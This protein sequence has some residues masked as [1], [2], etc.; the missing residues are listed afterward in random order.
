MPEQAC[1]TPVCPPADPVGCD[2]AK[3]VM[4]KWALISAIVAVVA[5]ALGFFAVAGAA[6][7]IAKF[8]FFL[9]LAIFVIVLLAGYFL[10]R[11]VKASLSRRDDI[12]RR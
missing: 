9:F 1:P 11:K 5:G 12:P 2:P 7:S 8:L 4:L 3:T 10:G 6:A